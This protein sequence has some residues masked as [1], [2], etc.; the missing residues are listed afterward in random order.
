MVEVDDDL[1]SR[2]PSTAS[3]VENAIGRLIADNLVDNGATL[4]MGKNLNVLIKQV[5]PTH[6]RHLSHE[7]HWQYP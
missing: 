4:Q 2:A 7:R 1:P 5:T 3:P 6:Q